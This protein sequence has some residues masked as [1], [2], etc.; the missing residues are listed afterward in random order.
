MTPAAE[1]QKL[2]RASK[3]PKKLHKNT[4][5]CT[6]EGPSKW[7]ASGPFVRLHGASRV[8]F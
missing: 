7:Q 3:N 4:S 8:M 6:P 2:A 5:H 1:A